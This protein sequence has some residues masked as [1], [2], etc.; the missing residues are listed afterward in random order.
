[1]ATSKSEAKRLDAQGA[2]VFKDPWGWTKLDV[3]RGCPQ[4]FKYKFID[5]RREPESPAM[6]RGGEIDK[7][8]ESYLNGWTDQIIGFTPSEVWAERLAKL[9]NVKPM[10]QAAWGVSADW[11][12]LPNW[13]HPET[14]LRAKSDVFY[15]KDDSLILIDIKTG[16]Y[17]VPS[18]DQVELYSIVGHCFHPEVKRVLA[19]F[20]FVDQD[21]V[22]HVEVYSPKK[23]LA[24]RA[25]Y[26]TEAAK[27]YNDRRFNPTP[28]E[29]CRWCSFSRQKGGP[30]K[31]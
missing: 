18:K 15:L 10:T 6:K 8:I 23:L 4:Q 1:M 29:P 14:R 24:L 20:W 13:F 19:Q 17:R 2:I 21:S 9:R 16:K 30:C 3:Y 12:P 11:R 26:D 31:Y 25:K 22:P 7:A 27:L 28:G 5:K